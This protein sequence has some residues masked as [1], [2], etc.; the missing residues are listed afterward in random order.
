M[1]FYFASMCTFKFLFSL[2]KLKRGYFPNPSGTT[3]SLLKLFM[4]SWV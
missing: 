2:S 3:P 1:N 4:K